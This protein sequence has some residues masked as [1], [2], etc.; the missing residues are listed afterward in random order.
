MIGWV[1]TNVTNDTMESSQQEGGFNMI[2]TEAPVVEFTAHD[3]CDGCGAQAYTLARS[4]FGELL[5]CL[6]H[7][8]ASIDSLLD[9]G[10]EIIDDYAAIER[11]VDGQPAGV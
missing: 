6:H 7:R 1:N 8:K 9:A 5:F 4:E 10:W 11:L 3:R 2:D